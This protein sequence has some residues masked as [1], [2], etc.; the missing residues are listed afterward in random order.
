[1]EMT[2]RENFVFE[3]FPEINDDQRE[4]ISALWDLYQAWNL[5]I[6]VISRKDIDALYLRHVLPSLSLVKYFAFPAGTT[7]LDIGTGGGF[8]GIPLAIVLPEISF[9]LIDGTRKKLNVVSALAQSL[10]LKNVTVLHRRVE[11]MQGRFD[12][13]V[14]RAVAPANKLLQ[15]CAPLMHTSAGN[16]TQ[17][18]MLKGGN[19]DEELSAIPN[20]YSYRKIALTDYFDEAFF[21]EKYLVHFWS[22]A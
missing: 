8:P 9:V 7:V 21:T 11:D 1:M 10:Q 19:L 3:Y 18:F 20:D 15:W 16:P 5:K 2:T 4:K 6:N 13:M 14:S 12:F 17:I 22:N